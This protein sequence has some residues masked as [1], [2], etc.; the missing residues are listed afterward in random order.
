MKKNL[1]AASIVCFTSIMSFA[2]AKPASF[3]VEITPTFKIN[4]F[5][6]VTIKAI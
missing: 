4:E 6:D 5:V 1:I 2:S 3:Q